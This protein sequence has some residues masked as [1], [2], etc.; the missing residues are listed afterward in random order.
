M[1]KF[2]LFIAALLGLLGIDPTALNVIAQNAFAKVLFAQWE[3]YKSDEENGNNIYKMFNYRFICVYV[4]KRGWS[5]LGP[6]EIVWKIKK[7]DKRSTLVLSSNIYEEQEFGKSY[8]ENIVLCQIDRETKCFVGT[9]R[10]FCLPTSWT[11]DLFDDVRGEIR[12]GS[13]DYDSV[14]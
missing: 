1:F 12:N 3:K 14:K 11:K 2:H 6:S 5:I 4:T 9:R 7:V 10:L 13:D 8:S